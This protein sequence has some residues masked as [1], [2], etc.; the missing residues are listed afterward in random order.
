[1]SLRIGDALKDGF[2]RTATRNGLVLIGVFLVFSAVNTVLSQSL[3]LATQQY[4]QQFSTQATQQTGAG[5]FGAA[6]TALAVPIPLPAALVLTLATMLLAEGL[7]IVGIRMF[8]PDETLPVTANSLRDGL[9]VAV[10]NGVVAGTIATV[11]T[12]L[13]FVFLIVPG[14]FIALSLFFVRQE[15]ALQNKNFIEALRDSWELSGGNRLELLGLGVLIFVI[16]LLASSPATVLFFLSPIPALLLGIV[17]SAVTTVFGIAV[18]TRAYQ[19]LQG[20]DTA[21]GTGASTTET[22]QSEG[23][24]L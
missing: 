9:P 6:Q 24:G 11:L 3:S 10:L 16:S 15:I 19:Q 5:S 13:G 22:T 7:R 12:Y 18:V 21:P 4:L 1:M 2:E 20:Q 17:T 14:V 8:A 23:V